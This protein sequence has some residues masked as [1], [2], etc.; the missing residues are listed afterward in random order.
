M[1]VAH[2]ECVRVGEGPGLQ[3]TKPSSQK[4]DDTARLSYLASALL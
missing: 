3:E 4:G 2:Q 1:G